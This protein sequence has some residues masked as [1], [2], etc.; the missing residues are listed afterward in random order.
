MPRQQQYDIDSDRR[1]ELKYFCRQ[2]NKWRRRLNEIHSAYTP[3]NLTGMP[4]GNGTSDPVAR[5]ALEAAEMSRKCELIEQCCREA[6]SINYR[7]LLKCVTEGLSWE[8]LSMKCQLHELT[9]IGNEKDFFLSR[10]RFFFLLSN[11]KK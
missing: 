11:R 6:D 9:W 5:A 10:K 2:Y 3:I 4:S 1:L 8:K 7:V